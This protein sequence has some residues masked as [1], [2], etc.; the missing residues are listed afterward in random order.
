M[1]TC[2]NENDFALPLRVRGFEDCEVAGA[3]LVHGVGL[4]LITLAAWGGPEGVL[5]TLQH[6]HIPE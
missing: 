3:E 6:Q 2:R 4:T 1:C 5:W